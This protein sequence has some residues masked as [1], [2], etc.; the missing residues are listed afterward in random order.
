MIYAK[1]WY[2]KSLTKHSIVFFT[3]V[4]DKVFYESVFKINQNFDKFDMPF[5]LRVWSVWK[6]DK[7]NE[8]W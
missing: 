8:F 4:F 1:N 2:I 7:P 5:N 6:K 3:T